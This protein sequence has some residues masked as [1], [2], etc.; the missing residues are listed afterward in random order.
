MKNLIV[1]NQKTLENKINKISEGGVDNL[2]VLSDFDR[3]LTYGVVDGRKRPSLISIL[4]QGDE[5][6][7]DEY[8]ERAKE[9]F[10]KYH[11]YEVSSELNLKE[12]KEKMNE[13]WRTHFNLLSEKG[14][15]IETIE[16]LSRSKEIILRE[17]VTDFFQRA[18]DLEVPIVIFSASGCGEA[19]K[20]FCQDKEIDYPNVYFLVNEFYWNGK[21]KM[22]GVKEPI[23]H[24]LNKDETVLKDIP[25]V[26]KKVKGR[27]NVLLFGDNLEDVGMVEGFNADTILKVG[28]LN[29]EYDK[30][31][32][33]KEYK[34]KYDIVITEDDDFNVL[35]PIL[36]KIFNKG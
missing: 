26:F 28:F 24:S 8:S 31:N 11:P 17:G 29:R 5:Y 22:V 35:E 33:L 4:R 1:S 20:Y 18:T 3:T 14:L 25:E 32:R 27:K 34:D 30:E 13:W 36:N 2:H 16:K 7:D 12:K 6:L 15:T 21:G 10:E 19:I 23:I 9:L